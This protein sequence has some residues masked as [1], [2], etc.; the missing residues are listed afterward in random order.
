MWKEHQ[1][2][3]DME[4]SGT[5]DGGRKEKQLQGLRN[6]EGRGLHPLKQWEDPSLMEEDFHLWLP[7]KRIRSDPGYCS[8]DFQ[9]CRCLLTLI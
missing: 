6:R 7:R 8:S 3:H 4:D 2:P 5:K 1:V 9:E